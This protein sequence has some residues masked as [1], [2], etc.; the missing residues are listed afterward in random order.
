MS[1]LRES[2]YPASSGGIAAAAIP[3]ETA[4]IG[5]ERALVRELLRLVSARAA[6]EVKGS[7]IRAS[8]DAAADTE[9][10]RARQ[11]LADQFEVIK[12]GARKADQDRRRAIVDAALSGEA[13]AKAE[14][15]RA[16]RKIATDFDAV[17]TKAKNDYTQ[18]RS[19][20]P[21]DRNSRQDPRS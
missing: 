8:G 15:A 5:R 12:A 19:E 20:A 21:D 3:V 16:S 10:H 18:A 7:S 9:Y 4:L 1:S 13:E 6:S 11:V 2:P 14:F 17:R